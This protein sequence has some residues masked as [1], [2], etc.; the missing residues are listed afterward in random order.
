MLQSQKLALGLVAW[1][2]GVAGATQVCGAAVLDEASV[3]KLGQRMLLCHP[4]DRSQPV[5]FEVPTKLCEFES[6]PRWLQG[7]VSCIPGAC[8]ASQRCQRE[9]LRLISFWMPE[10]SRSKF[11]GFVYTGSLSK[12]LPNCGKPVLSPELLLLAEGCRS[13]VS[14]RV[15]EVAWWHFSG[16]RLQTRQTSECPRDG[17]F[18]SHLGI[19]GLGMT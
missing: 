14:T 3:R 2:A 8:E 10:I 13:A 17:D 11:L 7:L 6:L 5:D 9:E 18:P 19:G 12:T 16:Y 1:E 15:G 4:L